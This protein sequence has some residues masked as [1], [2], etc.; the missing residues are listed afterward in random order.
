MQDQN[1]ALIFKGMPRLRYMRESSLEDAL[2][3]PYYW[4]WAYLRLSK[5]YWWAC[6][7]KGKVDDP[8][9]RDMYRDFGDV[10]SV[11]FARW[12]RHQG[13]D[14][15][16]EQV[17]L[18]EVLSLDPRNLQLRREPEKSL[19]L[20]IP[21]NL[22]ERTIISQVR[23]LIRKHAN[24][25]VLRVSAARRKLAKFTG[26]KLDVIGKA[27]AVWRLYQ[28]TREGRTATAI[29]QTSGTK[30][31]YQIGKELRL[32]ES[33]MPVRMDSKEKAAKRVN[34]MKVA[35]SRM[36]TRADNLIA[37]AALGTFPSMQTPESPIFWR[38]INQKRLDAAVA[39]QEWHPLFDPEDRRIV[40]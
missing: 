25:K 30:S 2:K 31:Y 36:V 16:S 4:W 27:Q 12:W 29:G 39:N 14:L 23:K 11:R 21:I 40:Q 20:E 35:V 33:C 13:V 19:I 18:P 37:N 5:D 1:I 38:P 9:L 24:R 3:S 8:R 32:V 10:Y 6:K 26:I 17:A 7:L 22:T 28:Q 34:G 15:F